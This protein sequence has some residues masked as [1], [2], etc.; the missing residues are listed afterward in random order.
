MRECHKEPKQPF[1]CSTFCNKGNNLLKEKQ[2]LQAWRQ[3]HAFNNWHLFKLKKIKPSF[4]VCF[5]SLPPSLH[6]HSRS[7]AVSEL[8]VPATFPES[9][10]SSSI[11]PREQ[12]AMHN[13]NTIT[14]YKVHS[15]STEQAFSLDHVGAGIYCPADTTLS[16]FSSVN[17]AHLPS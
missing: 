4:Q 16:D 14:F 12:H 6:K 13:R 11:L 5:P 10:P 9:S 8:L 3:A 17:H 7:F 2:H 1:F 15:S